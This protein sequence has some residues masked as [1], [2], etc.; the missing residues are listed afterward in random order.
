MKTASLLLG[1]VF[2]IQLTACQKGSY[3]WFNP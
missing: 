3:Y 2:I 1:I